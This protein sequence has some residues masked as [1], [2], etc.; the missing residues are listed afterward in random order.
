M[1]RGHFARHPPRLRGLQEVVVGHRD[2]QTIHADLLMALRN[3]PV[4]PSR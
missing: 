2:G 1:S 3:T 4:T